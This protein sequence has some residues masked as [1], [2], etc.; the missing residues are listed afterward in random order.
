MTTLMTVSLID[1]DG[2]ISMNCQRADAAMPLA[3][4][5]VER[6]IEGL[7]LLREQLQPPVRTRDP[8]AGEQVQAQLDPR[9]WVA[10]EMFVG[11]ALLQLRHTR[12]GW[13]AFALP[14]QSLRDLHKSLGDLLAFSEQQAR[15]QKVN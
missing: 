15:A 12:F 3:A 14:L 5:H 13:L 10:P 6:L 11:G 8:V 1:E 7:G 4:E 9:W 2:R